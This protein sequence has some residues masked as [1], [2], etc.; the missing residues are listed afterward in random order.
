MRILAVSHPCT[1]DVNQQFYAELEALGHEVHVLVPANLRT[2]YAPDGVQVKRWPAYAG[3]LEQR[4]VFAS[5]SVPLHGYLTPLRPL[6]RRYAPEVLFVEE[7]PYAVSAW[8]AMR[9]SRGLPMTRV[10]Y[11]AQNIRKSYP[12]PFRWMEQYVLRAA[13]AAAVVSEDVGAVLRAKQYSG[14]LLPF[15]L[16][17]DTG[18]FRPLPETRARRRAELGAGDE[19]VVGYVGRF[20]EEKGIRVLCAAAEQLA[21]Q[22]AGQLGAPS[23][24]FLFVGG[25]PLLGELRELERRHPRAVTVREGVSHGEVH[26]WMNA[27]DVLALPSLTMPG[28]K[29]QFGRVIVEAMACG[30][31]V[32]GTDSGEIGRLLQATGGGWTVPERQPEA[33]A[34]QLLGLAARQAERE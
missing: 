33:L 34:A 19:L 24:R 29:E 6:M 18:Q 28:W 30:L 17:V 15:P 8:Q 12:P 20:V 31:P 22:P 9:A 11:S 32:V 26:E 13:D 27:M 14:R 21:A 10:V 3:T 1:T 16:G 7:E 25:G 5:G 4:R 23:C 2:A